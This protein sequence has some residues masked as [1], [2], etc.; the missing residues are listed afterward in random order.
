MESERSGAG[1]KLESLLSMIAKKPF[2]DISELLIWRTVREGLGGNVKAVVIGGGSLPMFL[3]DF[4]ETAKINLYVGYG[5][6]E[7]SPVIC[8]RSYEHNVP[9][10]VGLSP[11]EVTL[12]IVDTE[13]KEEVGV[14]EVGV[15]MAKGPNVTRGYY[16]NS[17]ATANSIDS[18]IGRA[19]V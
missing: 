10:T 13:T 11:P 17:E 2:Y 7:T 3:E 19:H 14:G 1:D 6:T 15:L 16:R 18:E 5:L 9:G 12:K 4:Y 8:N